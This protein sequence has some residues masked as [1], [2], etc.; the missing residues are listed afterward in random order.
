MTRL[1][2]IVFN[3]RPELV[4]QCQLVKAASMVLAESQDCPERDAV[5]KAIQA[6]ADA[7]REACRCYN[8]L[9]SLVGT[10]ERKL[11]NPAPAFYEGEI[12]QAGDKPT[13]GCN[14]GTL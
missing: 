9:R 13:P 4:A 8:D 6:Q 10:L 11:G 7:A 5:A 1:E 14:C 12:R 3:M 2:Q